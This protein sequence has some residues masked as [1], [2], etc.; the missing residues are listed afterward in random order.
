MTS[1][2]WLPGSELVHLKAASEFSDT[3]AITEKFTELVRLC[4]ESSQ[5]LGIMS[6]LKENFRNELQL[7]GW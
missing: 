3:F 6:G 1:D 7:K 5:P 4:F 2:G